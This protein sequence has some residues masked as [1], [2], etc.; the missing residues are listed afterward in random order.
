VPSREP[1]S[2]LSQFPSQPGDHRLMLD[3]PLGTLTLTERN[4]ALVAIDWGMQGRPSPTPLLERAADQLQ[5]YFD[6]RLEVFNLPLAPD[7]TAFQKQ[8]WAR[9]AQIPYGTVMTY[10]ALAKAIRS[11]P[12]AVGGACGRNPIPIILPCHRVLA[13][14]RSLTGYS[15]A[16]GTETKR[17]LLHLE[18]ALAPELSA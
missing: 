4:G 18:G 3:S 10:G 12:R 14:D 16:G 5:A 17:T 13:A 7:G 1:L 15:G 2:A 6:G 9:M 11:A 8:V